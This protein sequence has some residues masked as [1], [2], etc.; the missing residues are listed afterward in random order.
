MT[1]PAQPITPDRLRQLRILVADGVGGF[2]NEAIASLLAKHDQIG[3]LLEITQ[4]RLGS[5]QTL[6]A[7]LQRLA[8]YPSTKDAYATELAQ[9]IRFTAGQIVKA[10]HAGGPEPISPYTIPDIDPGYPGGRH[11]PVAEAPP[12]RPTGRKHAA[13][14]AV[15]T[16]VW[17]GGRWLAV[18]SVKRGDGW[19]Q[20]ADA[21]GSTATWEDA[22]LVEVREPEPIVDG[23]A[24]DLGTFERLTGDE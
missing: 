8:E 2:T 14:V 1:I 10:L 17:S 5:V 7:S 6:A 3:R 12:P 23:D 4:Q 20:F 13:D 11:E 24:P 18:A 15:G 16:Q 21:S 19:T 22:M 9:T